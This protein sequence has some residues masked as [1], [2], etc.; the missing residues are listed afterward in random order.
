M[1]NSLMGDNDCGDDDN[2]DDDNDDGKGETKSTTMSAQDQV[3]NTNYF[4]KNILEQEI[5]SKCRKLKNT[6]RLLT[7]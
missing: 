5:K 3:M 6:K 2:D 1:Q 7:S 4:K